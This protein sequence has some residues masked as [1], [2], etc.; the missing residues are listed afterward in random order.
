LTRVKGYRIADRKGQTEDQM[1]LEI[2]FTAGGQL[3]RLP[4]RRY[5]QE[6]KIEQF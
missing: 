3:M 1:S 5:G 6:W 2:Q 4:L